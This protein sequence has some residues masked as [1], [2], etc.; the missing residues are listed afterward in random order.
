V[1][2]DNEHARAVIQDM[3]ASM[4]FSAAAVESGA[5]ALAEIERAAR[6]GED[7]DI[8]F[9]DW[10]MPGMDGIETAKRIAAS[11]LSPAPHL[12]IVTAYGREEVIREA[13]AA[14]IKDVLIKPVSFS[15]LFDT[16]MHLLG[17][18]RGERR[19]AVDQVTEGLASAGGLGGARILLVEDN[20]LNQEVAS[21]ILRIAGCS[22]S[23]AAD[24]TAAID[25]VREAP[26]DIVLMDVQMPGM[27]GLTATRE[28]RKM[29][30]YGALPIIAMTANA[31]KED[32]E[33]CLAA[34]MNDY[35]TKPIDPDRLFET[36][37]RYYQGREGPGDAPAMPAA[38]D[39][40]RN[41]GDMP[42]I[43]GIDVEGGLRRVMGNK[44]LY[45]DLLKRFSEGQRDTPRGV[46]EAL[47][48]GDRRLAERLAHTLKGVSG[49]IGAAGVQAAAAA[50]ESAIEGGA[51][52]GIVAGQLKRLSSVAAEA[53]GRIDAALAG[54]KA[55]S[56]GRA[57]GSGVSRPLTELLERLARYAEE[58]DCEALDFFETAREELES[59]Y[60][61]KA[62]EELEKRMRAYDFKGVLE[63]VRG[64]M[65]SRPEAKPAGESQDGISQ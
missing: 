42:I 34:G 64:I 26:Y 51:D 2:D 21:E 12:V 46:G 32:R 10:Q 49:N 17:T 65:P 47:A 38:S 19:E 20:E 18:K 59:S 33:Q 29:E 36:L 40:N 31:T 4:S 37:R 48:A 6:A 27:D 50:L 14:G 52:A 58:N 30:G 41:E 43:E 22:I 25:K 62:V 23:L 44:A 9:I 11:G 1:V 16:A 53:I 5:A 3:L 15:I 54:T 57:N 63:A 61:K 55:Q 56:N 28:I 13:E 24:G 35:V 8:V 39:A 7:Y 45:L 60:G